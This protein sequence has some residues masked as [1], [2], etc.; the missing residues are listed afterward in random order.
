MLYTWNQYYIVWLLY[1]N[2]KLKSK[3][4]SIKCN[5][6][7]R[8]K[9]LF[10]HILCCS[11]I[12]R[13]LLQCRYNF[14]RKTLSVACTQIVFKILPCLL[15]RPICPRYSIYFY[16]NL[17]LLENDLESTAGGS[18]SKGCDFS[19]TISLNWNVCVFQIYMNNT[20]RKES[21]C[22]DLNLLPIFISS[23]ILSLSWKL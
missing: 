7:K 13:G 19:C 9:G 3:Y 20:I 12:V 15:S 6:W 21:L 22:R 14:V 5:W 4:I 1:F 17:Y 2:K 10:S 23:I 18:T 8:F 16:F 11:F